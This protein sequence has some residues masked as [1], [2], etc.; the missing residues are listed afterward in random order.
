ML[1]A[2]IFTVSWNWRNLEMHSYTLRPHSAAVTMCAKLSSRRT[3]SA[4]E[5]V[6][7]HGHEPANEVGTYKCELQ[8]ASGQASKDVSMYS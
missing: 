1:T 5:G 3:Y 4:C 8:H 2:T 6:G 7:M